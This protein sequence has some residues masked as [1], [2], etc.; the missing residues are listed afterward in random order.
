MG[1]EGSVIRG[2]EEERR[3]EEER[4]E[5][6]EE[7]R[8]G[9]EERRGGEERRRGEY[10]KGRRGGEERRRKIRSAEKFHLTLNFDGKKL[11]K[12]EIKLD[13]GLQ[14]QIKMPQLFTGTQ[15]SRCKFHP[16][17]LILCLVS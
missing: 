6:G 16:R 1:R 4:K 10:D 11:H 13:I 7:D 9:E 8:R 15:F 3:G 2:G 17:S 14:N 12:K 5:R